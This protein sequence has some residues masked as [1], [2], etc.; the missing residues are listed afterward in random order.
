MS[1]VAVFIHNSTCTCIYECINIYTCMLMSMSAFFNHTT[2][3]FLCLNVF[4][5]HYKYILYIFPL[6]PKSHQWFIKIELNCTLKIENV[7]VKSLSWIITFFGS[8]WNWHNQNRVC[9]M[10]GTDKS[11]ENLTCSPPEQCPK[12]EL[13]KHPLIL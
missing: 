11:F 7:L 2:L 6:G 5:V 12:L 9:T 3:S 1:T 4:I 8:A 10:K 13:L